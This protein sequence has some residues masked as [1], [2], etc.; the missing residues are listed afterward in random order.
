V[1]V[2]RPGVKVTTQPSSSAEVQNARSYTCTRHMLLHG[3]CEDRDNFAFAF[4]LH[5][6]VR[7][8]KP[9]V[10]GIRSVVLAMKRVSAL[11]ASRAD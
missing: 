11:A 8:P 5:Y 1:E 2:K 3:V 4:Y 7:T 9:H 10:T 6:V